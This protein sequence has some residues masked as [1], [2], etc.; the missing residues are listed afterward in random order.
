MKLR[1]ASG[2]FWSEMILNKKSATQ[3]ITQR[4]TP[5]QGLMV[6][7]GNEAISSIKA[8]PKH[9]Y[10]IVRKVGSIGGSPVYHG[11]GTGN[12]KYGIQTRTTPQGVPYTPLSE[13]T[14]KI[15]RE[16][17]GITRGAEYILRET[18]KHIMQGLKVKYVSKVGGFGGG[19]KRVEIGWS[20]LDEELIM[21]NEKNR[22]IPNPIKR[23]KPDS[24]APDVLVPARKVR[25][26]SAEFVNNLQ[27]MIIDYLGYR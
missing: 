18:S 20:G 10:S 7:I 11:F 6:A 26:F 1:D 13:V 14:L 21:M 2:G 3:V 25:G 27:Q 23:I 5:N 22:K 19:A 24:T 8:G 16:A 15:R 4:I 12:Y 17:K 9:N